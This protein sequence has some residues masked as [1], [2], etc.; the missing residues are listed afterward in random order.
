MYFLSHGEVEVLSGDGKTVYA[1]L[2]EG[3]YFGEIALLFEARRIAHIRTTTYCD[4]LMLTKDDFDSVLCFFPTLADEMRQKAKEKISEQRM[5]AANRPPVAPKRRVSLLPLTEEEEKKMQEKQSTLARSDTAFLKGFRSRAL[6]KTRNDSVDLGRYFSDKQQR[7]KSRDSRHSQAPSSVAGDEIGGPSGDQQSGRG[8]DEDGTDFVVH[9]DDGSDGDVSVTQ[10]ESFSAPRNSGASR[11]P[12]DGDSTCVVSLEPH[13]EPSSASLN[14]DETIIPAQNPDVELL[15][16]RLGEQSYSA[17]AS[18]SQAPI[19]SAS[20]GPSNAPPPPSV[21]DKARP[22]QRYFRARWKAIAYNALI[23][24]YPQDPSTFETDMPVMSIPV[25]Q[26]VPDPNPRPSPMQQSRKASLRPPSMPVASQLKERMPEMSPIQMSVPQNVL[27]PITYPAPSLQPSIPPLDLPV[28][29]MTD[30]RL[31]QGGLLYQPPPVFNPGLF[32]PPNG[33]HPPSLPN[34]PPLPN[35][36]SSIFNPP[37]LDPPVSV[38]AIPP[39]PPAASPIPQHGT[40][41]SR[42][43][44]SIVAD[45]RLFQAVV[46]GLNTVREDSP[47]LK[48]LETIAKPSTFGK[49]EWKQWLE[50]L[51]DE[52]RKKPEEDADKPMTEEDVYE[53]RMKSFQTKK[54]AT[55]NRRSSYLHGEWRGS[56]PSTPK[57]SSS[58]ADAM[59]PETEERQGPE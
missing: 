5:Q 20:S 49:E 41:R 15:N 26:Q 39:R 28:P 21:S 18:G 56:N 14:H 57:N 23:Q 13:P 40:G 46:N 8:D 50:F 29:L 10:F 6:Q 33:F 9:A 32:N 38:V 54:N 52:V 24:R 30:D 37:P 43:R 35:P 36:M 2:K 48:E 19:S 31:M 47:E 51:D 12:Q 4:L 17:N 22:D 45:Q 53:K 27:A 25:P 34:P 55:F 7:S 3:S 58:M 1:T 16:R 44:P 59:I 11:E 42:P